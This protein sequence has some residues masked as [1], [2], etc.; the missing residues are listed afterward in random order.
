MVLLEVLG[1][2]S[3]ISTMLKSCKNRLVHWIAI[4]AI[5][6]SALAPAI[7]QAVSV[8]NTGHGFSMEICS[9][10]GI[11][12]IQVAVGDEQEQVKASEPCPYCLAHVSYAL[13][14]EANLAFSKPENLAS[15]PRLFY[16]SPKPLFAWVRLPSRAPPANS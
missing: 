10:D 6:M 3:K 5:L 9:V 11:K 16:Q 4:L 15:Y 14:L 7:S 12:T 13:P 8:S 1:I 2:N